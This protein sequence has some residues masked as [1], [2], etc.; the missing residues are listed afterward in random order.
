MACRAGSLQYQYAAPALC[1][2]TPMPP[3]W[4]EVS[5]VRACLSGAPQSVRRWCIA[6]RAAGP[7]RLHAAQSVSAPAP[8]AGGV[9]LSAGSMPLPVIAAAWICARLRSRCLPPQWGAAGPV[10]RWGSGGEC[11]QEMCRVTVGRLRSKPAPDAKMR[12]GLW[13]VLAFLRCLL[14][15]KRPN[16][17]AENLHYCVVAL[18]IRKLFTVTP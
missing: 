14:R 18:R 1:I 17:R 11:H 9:M 4:C 10:M 12:A 7:S 2:G 6:S 5:A 13:I 15:M 8:R 16:L 3:Q